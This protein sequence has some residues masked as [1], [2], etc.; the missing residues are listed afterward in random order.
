[1]HTIIFAK[2]PITGRVKTRLIP[3][4]GEAAAARLAAQMLHRILGEAVAAG[5]GTIELCGTPDR[6]DPAWQTV[7]IPDQVM[8]TSQGQ[9]DLGTIM[10]RAIARAF[11]QAGRVILAGTDCPELDRRRLRQAGTAL[12]THDAVL[13][14]AVDGGYV[15]LG[16]N[17]FNPGIMEGIRWSTP[18]VLPQTLERLRQLGY[19][20]ALQPDVHDIDDPGD[21]IWLPPA[22][23][24][25]LPEV[26]DYLSR[27]SRRE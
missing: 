14:P 12:A 3:A 11:E 6:E 5:M 2:A 26:S 20:V 1:M 25:A 10:Q 15:L 7:R 23:R 16:L 19:S 21:L 22:L 13:V 18:A 8:H 17:R 24:A 9:G 4:I 27:D